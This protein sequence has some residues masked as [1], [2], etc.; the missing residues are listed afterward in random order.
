M[1]I[2]WVVSVSA[3][4]LSIEFFIGFQF[5]WEKPASEYFK[6]NTRDDEDLP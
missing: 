1:S 6:I 4:S 5:G 3:L 2:L